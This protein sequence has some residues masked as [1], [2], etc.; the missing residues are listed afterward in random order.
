MV[1]GEAD[2]GTGCRTENAHVGML[3]TLSGSA[4]MMMPDDAP[5]SGFS[6]GLKKAGIKWNRSSC[7][8]P[9]P[10]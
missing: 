5:G 1:A 7:S 6:A 3:G 10:F 2:S 4:I 8:W 9:F